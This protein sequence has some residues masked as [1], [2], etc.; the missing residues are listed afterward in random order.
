M[1]NI[2]VCD[3]NIS[4]KC[5]LA[6]A[7]KDIASKNHLYININTFHS[8]E[9]LLSEDF[10]LADII[11]IDV[12]LVGK[13]NG[14]ETAKEIRKRGCCSEIIFIASSDEYVYEAYDIHPL[15]V[16]YLIKNR[17][18]DEEFESVFLRAFSLAQKKE[19]EVFT[20]KTHNKRKT[21]P[22]RDISH[23]IMKKCMVSV[24]YS[25]KEISFRSSM[26]YLQDQL[27]KRNFIRTH[28]SYIIN[29]SYVSCIRQKSVVLTTGQEVPIGI[30]YSKIFGQEFTRYLEDSNAVR[31]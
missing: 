29:L 16:Q 21:I 22:L 19:R 1:I 25:E 24:F 6:S 8:G 20:I 9:E 31:I 28:R 15:P 4:T 3:N 7:I 5:G 11:Y 17:I 10:E 2:Y 18:T 27:S 13:L 26:L 14:I 12:T 30:T 23:F